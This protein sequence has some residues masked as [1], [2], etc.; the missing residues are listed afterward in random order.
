RYFLTQTSFA[1]YVALGLAR[2]SQT[3]SPEKLNSTWSFAK[4]SGLVFSDGN[5]RKNEVYLQS[6]SVGIHYLSEYG[7]SATLEFTGLFSY[8]TNTFIPWG[9]LSLG[10][11]F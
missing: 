3:G 5:I 9:G 7:F 4:D 10:W 11:Y 6:S 1:P 2:W 8:E